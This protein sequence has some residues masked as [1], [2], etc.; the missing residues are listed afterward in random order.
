MITFGLDTINKIE[1]AIKG[2]M[3]R[4]SV[5]LLDA[6]MAF[7]GSKFKVGFTVELNHQPKDAS[8]LLSVE[9][10]FKPL[11]DAKYQTEIFSNDT[12]LSMFRVDAVTG[13]VL[14]DQTD[15]DKEIEDIKR[16]ETE[17]SQYP[18]AIRTEDGYVF[19]EQ[20]DGSWGDGDQTWDSFEDMVAG[21]KDDGIS[22]KTVT[23]SYPPTDEGEED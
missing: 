8:N 17:A 12:Q 9:M 21:L 16:M 10:K 6:Y 15:E 22:W 5:E 20:E 3:M 11:P 4:R 19:Q 7:E 14:D 23:S 18:N 2:H 1:Q 13:E